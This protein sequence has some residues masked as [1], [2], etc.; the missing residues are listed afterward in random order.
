MLLNLLTEGLNHPFGPMMSMVGFKFQREWSTHKLWNYSNGTKTVVLGYDQNRQPTWV[1][2]DGDTE[3]AKG[4]D[5]EQLLAKLGAKNPSVQKGEFSH[6]PDHM[7]KN[8]GQSQNPAMKGQLSRL[9]QSTP[10]W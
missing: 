1:I 10:G 6:L 9:S 3:I 5:K 4:N 8:L 7:R 2:K